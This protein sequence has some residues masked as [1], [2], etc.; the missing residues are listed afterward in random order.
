MFALLSN[1]SFQKIQFNEAI[2]IKRLKYTLA[3]DSRFLVLKIL[4][5][6]LTN[7]TVIHQLKCLVW[8][9]SGILN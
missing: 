7:R 2:T 3:I 4:L 5:K 1:D 9:G 8:N 6:L